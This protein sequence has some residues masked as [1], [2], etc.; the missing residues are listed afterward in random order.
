MSHGYILPAERF[1][2]IAPISTFLKGR[3]LAAVFPYC[4]L[5]ALFQWQTLNRIPRRAGNSL[6]THPLQEAALGHRCSSLANTRCPIPY[7]MGCSQGYCVLGQRP[8]ASSIQSPWGQSHRRGGDSSMRG[9]RHHIKG[10]R[11]S[12]AGG[13]QCRGEIQVSPYFIFQSRLLSAY[14]YREFLLGN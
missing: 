6:F 9:D 2:L 4:Q 11:D 14:F 1:A 10:S 3:G 8:T 13:R 7:R 5:R 12:R